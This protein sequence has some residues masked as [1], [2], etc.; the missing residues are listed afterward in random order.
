VSAWERVTVTALRAHGRR[1]D[2][3][4]V[5]V[6]GA[7]AF[8]LPVER[9]AQLSVGQ[10]LG[11]EEL[12]VLRTQADLAAGLEVAM[13]FLA[14]RPRSRAETAARLARASVARATAELVLARLE[15]CGLVDDA[16]FARWWVEDRRAHRPTARRGLAYE[17]AARGVPREVV[18]AALA[19][20]EDGELAA[21]AAVERAPRLRGLERAEFERRLSGWLARRA[22]APEDVRT[23]VAVAW[24]SLAAQQE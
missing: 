24:S 2:L 8:T 18:D 4:D 13:R 12:A 3:V 17:L 5:Q 6:D 11:A 10:Q 1:T 23:A 14:A 21:A 16:A 15:A 9:A 19:G 20:T 7:A 22:F